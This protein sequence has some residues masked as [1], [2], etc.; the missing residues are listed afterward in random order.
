MSIYKSEDP[1][2]VSTGFLKEP[3]PLE[4]VQKEIESLKK[5]A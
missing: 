3:S 2:K 4:N 5:Q 1:F